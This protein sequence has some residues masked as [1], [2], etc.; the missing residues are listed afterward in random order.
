VDAPRLAVSNGDPYR[1]RAHA[2]IGA[3]S[4]RWLGTVLTPVRPDPT[5]SR[6]PAEAYQD[7]DYAIT[8]LRELA[9]TSGPDQAL[10]LEM[11]RALEDKQAQLRLRRSGQTGGK[12]HSG[13][14]LYPR[15]PLA[16]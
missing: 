1:R 13:F 14:A 3:E 2:T 10:Y 12:K 5:R 16:R 15:Q 7:N 4:G 11:L 8:L 6:D 9:T